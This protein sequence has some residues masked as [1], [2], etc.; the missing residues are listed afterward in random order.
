VLIL[1][2][3]LMQ[4]ADGRKRIDL[5]DIYNLELGGTWSTAQ[6]SVA[7]NRLAATS[8][9]NLVFFAGGK[10]ASLFGFSLLRE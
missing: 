9:P 10:S 5:V 6:L 1:F 4:C 2:T 7:R 8:L 3:C